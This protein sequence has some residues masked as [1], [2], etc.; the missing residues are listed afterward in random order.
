MHAPVGRWQKGKDIYWYAK[1]NSE[2]AINAAEEKQRL[3]D[4]DEELINAALGI[5]TKP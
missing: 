3:K 2:A 4:L 1:A 5:K